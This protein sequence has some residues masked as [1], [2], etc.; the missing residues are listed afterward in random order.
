MK[1][2][3]VKTGDRRYRIEL[4][5]GDISEFTYRDLP[6]PWNQDLYCY[7]DFEPGADRYS[8]AWEGNFVD[9][10]PKE[11]EL[12]CFLIRFAYTIGEEHLIPSEILSEFWLG[13]ESG[14]WVD[15]W[16]C[17]DQIQVIRVRRVSYPALRKLRFTKPASQA[18]WGKE[19]RSEDS[20]GVGWRPFAR[21][22]VKKEDLIAELDFTELEKPRK[23]RV[24]C[25]RDWSDWPDLSYEAWMGRKLEK[26]RAKP[27]S[28]PISDQEC[29]FELKSGPEAEKAHQ[30]RKK[31]S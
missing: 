12:L 27:E 23:R 29:V 2:R 13:Y 4:P 8:L 3:M 18:L 22:K 17:P 20:G 25:S 5:G 31:A 28:E 15:E 21:P 10:F 1:R 9:S 6:R 11:E 24:R 26:A 19:R 7:L 16:G 14:Y 30:A